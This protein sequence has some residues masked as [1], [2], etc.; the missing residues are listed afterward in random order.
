MSEV[1]NRDHNPFKSVLQRVAYFIESNKQT[2]STIL[3]RLMA[4]CGQS[5]LLEGTVAV[6]VRVF[7]EFMKSK[8][9]KK[10]S[11]GEL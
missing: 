5:D 8:I 9:D 11:I 2:V 7:A 6:S 3:R 4:K 10:R 1:S